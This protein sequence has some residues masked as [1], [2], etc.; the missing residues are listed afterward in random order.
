MRGAHR[1]TEQVGGFDVAEGNNLRGGALS[2]GQVRLADLLTDRDDDALP[3]DHRAETQRQ[4]HRELHPVRNE[5]GHALQCRLILARGI[6]IQLRRQ[7]LRLGQPGQRLGHQIDVEAQSAALIARNR[8]EVLYV[9]QV[10]VDEAGRGA[11]RGQRFRL[12]LAM[13][14]VFG[15][16]LVCCIERV[17]C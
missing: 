6:R 9:L 2:V 15:Q 13:T 11:E 1:Q 10:M 7:L 5:V 14:Q 3:A 8:A 4:G 17:P 12:Y 16:R